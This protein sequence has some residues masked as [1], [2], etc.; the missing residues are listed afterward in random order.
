[1][2][3]LL[4]H[5]NDKTRYES[6]VHDPPQC[7]LL[8]AAD[9]SGKKTILSNLAEQIA[10]HKENIIILELEENKKTIGIDAIRDLKLSLRLKTSQKRVILIPRAEII[11]VEAQNSLLKILEE[12]PENVHFLMAVN[13]IY[14]VLETIRSRTSIWR[15]TPPTNKQLN[16]YFEKYDEIQRKRAFSIGQSRVG[17]ICSILTNS[18]NHELLHSIDVAKEILGENH[19][20]R[21]LRVD[22]Y[23]KDATQFAKLLDGLQLTCQAALEHA[24]IKKMHSVQHW[25]RRLV[26]VTDA[27]NLLANNIQ[28]KLVACQLFIKL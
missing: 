8:V 18:E 3:G 17:L 12:P 1:M 6:I 7:L 15:L 21:L 10:K 27:Q 26:V 24:A 28:P 11:T 9:G 19:F 16:D 22:A 2:G 4:L 20:E 14:D 13:Q 23:A 25:H 5:P